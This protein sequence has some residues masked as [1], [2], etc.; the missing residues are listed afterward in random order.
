LFINFKRHFCLF[1]RRRHEANSIIHIAIEYSLGVSLPHPFQIIS[2]TRRAAQEAQ[3]NMLIG[4]VMTCSVTTRVARRVAW[5]MLEKVSR[6]SIYAA[7]RHTDRFVIVIW[8]DDDELTDLLRPF[9]VVRSDAHNEDVG[10][11]FNIY[12]ADIEAFVR[13]GDFGHSMSLPKLIFIVRS[14]AGDENNCF[15]PRPHPRAIGLLIHYSCG[16]EDT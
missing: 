8:T 11:I 13:R 9:N 10:I 5:L 2:S 1:A 12:V 14:R 16:F 3:Q 4:L 15:G 7:L 6:L